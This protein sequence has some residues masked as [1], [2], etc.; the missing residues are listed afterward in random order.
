[1]TETHTTITEVHTHQILTSQ[2]RLYAQSWSLPPAGANG[3]TPIILLHDSLGCVPLWRDFP[4][5]LALATG[6]PV[7][8]YDRLGFG[9]SDPH[10]GTLTADFIAQEA[11]QVMPQVLAAFDIDRFIA[12]GHSVGGAM[13]VQAAAQFADACKGSLRWA[14]RCLSRNSHSTEYA[15]PNWTSQSRRTCPGWTNITATKAAGLWTPGPIPG[16]HR[17]FHTGMYAMNWRRSGVQNWLF[18]VTAIHT[19]LSSTLT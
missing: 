13:A 8:A 2:G 6:H 12:C 11:T 4:E 17:T 15:R 10:P 5:K 16:Y 7:I 14:H 9:R 18:M 1:M 19:A 3:Q